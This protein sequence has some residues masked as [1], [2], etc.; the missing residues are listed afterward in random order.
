VE[1]QVY[2][3]ADA[4]GPPSWIWSCLPQEHRG[5]IDVDAV[6]TL[7]AEWTERRL[8]FE[9]DGR[10]V[11]LAVEGNETLLALHREHDELPV[12]RF[13]ALGD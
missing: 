5:R 10:Y 4:G 6:A 11:A 7:L 8:M 13:D 3:A 2:L 1:G 12:E 9:E